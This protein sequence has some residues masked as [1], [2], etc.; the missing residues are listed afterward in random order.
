MDVEELWVEAGNGAEFFFD[1]GTAGGH[2]GSAGVVIP[3]MDA[4]KS[5]TSAGGVADS[6]GGGGEAAV[7]CGTG[8]YGS[9][10]GEDDGEFDGGGTTSEE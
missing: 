9:H 7:I 2:E 10:D 4:A 3:G 8:E 5:G 1:F 6:D